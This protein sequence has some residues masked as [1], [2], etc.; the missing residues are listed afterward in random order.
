L[1][2]L[3]LK[4][5]TILKDSGLLLRKTFLFLMVI[6]IIFAIS[7]SGEIG[8]AQ[9]SPGAD[10]DHLF[11]YPVNESLRLEGTADIF[12]PQFGLE[13]GCRFKEAKY[14]CAPAEKDVIDDAG[15]V[16]VRE[17]KGDP[18][19]LIPIHGSILTGDYVCYEV[20]CANITFPE[21]LEVTDQFD[22][23]LFDKSSPEPIENPKRKRV[24][25]REVISSLLCGPAVKGP[26]PV[27]DNGVLEPGEECDS[28][29]D[30]CDFDQDGIIDSTC[31]DQCRCPMPQGVCGDGVVDPGEECDDN[32]TISGDGCSTM[33]LV[34]DGFACEIPGEPCHEITCGDEVAEGNEECDPPG[35]A[36]D[37]N[38]DGNIDDGKCDDQ[39]Q[40]RALPAGC[41]DAV[42]NG[43]E[44]DV[45][46]GGSCP[47]CGDGDNCLVGNDCQS[48]F[49][50]AGQ[51][52]FSGNGVIDPGEECDNGA[53]NSDSLPDAC[54]TNCTSPFCGD[55]VVDTGEQ[56]DDGFTTSC[57][58]C[59]STCSGPGTGSV[60]G[61]GILCP[62]TEA[63]DDGFNTQCGT[64]NSTCSGPGTG[65]VCGDGFL[66]PDTEACDDGNNVDGDG[67][68]ANC[69]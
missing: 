4:E 50:P 34:E 29:G 56:C 9:P 46:C 31:D 64:C 66:C 69:L 48:G 49:C 42:K 14:F 8:I 52:E 40:C 20:E 24:P 33:C 12:V 59:N 7:K 30:G 36:C 27:C 13:P 57:G 32:N 60:C 23:H 16:T 18:F 28:P 68:S 55:N 17:K 58:T 26:A 51:C 35:G 25:K 22:T 10:T 43:N 65:S 61:D 21:E 67:C 11:C 2:K 39:C 6:G 41:L 1:Y 63:C 37:F 5:V 19:Q 3:H 62:D 54:R 15:N 38:M 44:T 47:R 45:D 53:D